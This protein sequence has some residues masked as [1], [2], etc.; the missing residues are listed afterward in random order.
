MTGICRPALVNCGN[1]AAR[2][3]PKSLTTASIFGYLDSSD[4]ITCWVSAGSQLVTLYGF[5]PMMW[6]PG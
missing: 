3:V 5:W 1:D 2:A 6:M 4:A